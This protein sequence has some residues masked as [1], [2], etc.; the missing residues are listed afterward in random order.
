MPSL[1]SPPSRAARNP[2]APGCTAVDGSQVPAQRGC[3][4]ASTSSAP[5][6]TC[7]RVAAARKRLQSA[8]AP[9]VETAF[10]IRGSD[11]QLRRAFSR[12]SG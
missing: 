6:I 12:E 11:A 9:G 5:T 4:A 2:A 10:S 8:R 7:P 1:A 3:P